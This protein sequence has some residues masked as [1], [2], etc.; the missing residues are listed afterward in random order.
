MCVCVHMYT[1]YVQPKFVSH[2]Q[3]TVW[4][5]FLPLK[6]LLY[7]YLDSLYKN[8]GFVGVVDIFMSV[9]T[10]QTDAFPGASRYAV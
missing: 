3:Y 2:T 10:V 6:L 7:R 9:M 5:T 8:H 4:Q 1:M